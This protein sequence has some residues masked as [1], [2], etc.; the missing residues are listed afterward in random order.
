MCND[1]LTLGFASVSMHLRFVCCF[2]VSD[3]L[4]KDFFFF[5]LNVLIKS[6]KKLFLDLNSWIL[7]FDRTWKTWLIY[8][9]YMWQLTKAMNVFLK[10]EYKPSLTHD[11]FLRSLQVLS[12]IPE[13]QTS[14]F[15][16]WP[17]SQTMS[18]GVSLPLWLRL[19]PCW[20]SW[21]SNTHSLMSRGLTSSIS[22]TLRATFRS[23][24]EAQTVA[25]NFRDQPPLPP[26]S[27]WLRLLMSRDVVSGSRCG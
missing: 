12:V 16:G 8:N 27:Q 18:R 17:Q 23:L 25:E 26:L 1:F 3:G 20:F 2:F 4:C 5:I 14:S 6:S 22:D 13:E 15:S 19:L 9:S 10:D 24:E 11:S 7:T 21:A